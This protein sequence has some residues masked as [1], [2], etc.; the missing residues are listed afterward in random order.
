MRVTTSASGLTL[1]SVHVGSG[2]HV[3]AALGVVL[4]PERAPSDAHGLPLG[5][6]CDEVAALGEGDD[7]VS[8]VL[9]RLVAAHPLGVGGEEP[10]HGE[11][12]GIEQ[13]VR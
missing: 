13:R 12:V 8:A 3:P 1:A 6:V 11:L 7:L 9:G 2:S 5:W 4:E 10:R